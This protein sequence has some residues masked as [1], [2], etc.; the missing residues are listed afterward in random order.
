MNLLRLEPFL[1]IKW[2]L[3]C[4][5][6]SLI[7]ST[8]N[9]ILLQYEIFKKIGQIQDRTGEIPTLDDALQEMLSNYKKRDRK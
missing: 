9:I 8:H 3:Q 2:I 7:Q 6:K 4:F 1:G 5:V